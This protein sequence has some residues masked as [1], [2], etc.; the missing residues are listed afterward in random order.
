M[1]PRPCGTVFA[2]SIAAAGLSLSAPTADA[3]A[4]RGTLK[5]IADRGEI[6]L[7]HRDA[8]IPFSYLDGAGK[9]VGFSVDLCREVVEAVKQRLRRPDLKVSVLPVTSAT[10]I[11]LVANATVDLECG[12]T[13]NTVARQAQVA[14]S[15][16]TYV[17]AG[18]LLVKRG[19]GI[20]GIADLK[21]KAVAANQ[22]SS[23]VRAL[24]ALN[25]DRRLGI[26]FL[27][28]KDFAESFVLLINLRIPM[29]EALRERLRTPDDRGVQ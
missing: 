28:A 5:K 9:P 10:R 13:T 16:T 25:A 22:G 14:F 11:P 21:G 18:R 20:A 8:A 7:G 6:V 3:Q 27:P 23:P 15:V 19:S 24:R 26:R 1:R 12:S 2:A 29:S 17:A 4:L